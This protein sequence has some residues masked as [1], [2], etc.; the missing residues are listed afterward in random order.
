MNAFW[1]TELVIAILI[2]TPTLIFAYK[3]YKIIYKN[4]DNLAYSPDVIP[5][6]IDLIFFCETGTK[7][8]LKKMY[9]EC[10]VLLPNNAPIVQ[11]I[12]RLCCWFALLC[13]PT[14][15]WDYRIVIGRLLLVL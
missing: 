13:Y 15:L 10:I 9:V 7:S 6:L 1:W 8:Y 5:N 14:I 11:L 4:C 2:W 12:K 3:I